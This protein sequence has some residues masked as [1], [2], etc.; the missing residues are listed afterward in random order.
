MRISL[1]VVHMATHQFILTYYLYKYFTVAISTKDKK[2]L[3]AK[4]QVTCIPTCL[5]SYYLRKR[6][7]T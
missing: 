4:N 3:L 1:K 6:N 5:A 2:K 7:K